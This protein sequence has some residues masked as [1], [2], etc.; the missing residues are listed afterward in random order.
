MLTVRNLISELRKMPQNLPVGIAL[1]DNKIN[2]IAGDV[3]HVEET[4]DDYDPENKVKYVVL[5]C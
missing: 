5:R 1:P 3:N 4:T 2:E